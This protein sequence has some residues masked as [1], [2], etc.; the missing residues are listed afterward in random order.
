M[1]QEYA[2]R[3][4]VPATQRRIAMQEDNRERSLALAEWKKKVRACWPHVRFADI[5]SGPLDGLPYGSNL[6]VTADLF[7]DKLSTGDVTVEIYYGTVDSYGRIHDG[8]HAPMQL[9][10]TMNDGVHRFKGLIYCDK[11]GQQGFT[12]RVVP[13]HPD[14]AQKHETALIS[15]A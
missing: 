8:R 14:L 9:E 5:E 13:S 12:V 3:F 4:Y 2:D 10:Q 11:T 6:E 15:W 7:L 1:V